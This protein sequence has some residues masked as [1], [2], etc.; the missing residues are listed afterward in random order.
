MSIG[1]WNHRAYVERKMAKGEYAREVARDI[2]SRIRAALHQPVWYE[3]DADLLAFRVRCLVYLCEH[4]DT[5]TETDR[6][7]GMEKLA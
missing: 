5:H 7:Q 4:Y 1:T 3:A 2:W 6:Y